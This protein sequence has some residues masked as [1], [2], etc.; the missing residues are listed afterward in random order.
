MNYF[1]QIYHFINRHIPQ[2]E[3]AKAIS[4]VLFQVVPGLVCKKDFH[5]ERVD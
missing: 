1:N 4:S 5:N 2:K 3:L